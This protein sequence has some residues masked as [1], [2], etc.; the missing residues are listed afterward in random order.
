MKIF[1]F[2]VVLT[3]KMALSEII[4][5]IFII[6]APKYNNI[7]IDNKIGGSSLSELYPNKHCV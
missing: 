2:F 3:L 7:L 1:E 4:I 5:I 6:S